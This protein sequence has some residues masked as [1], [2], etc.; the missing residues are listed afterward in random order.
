MPTTSMP[1]DTSSN[2]AY[3]AVVCRNIEEA[4]KRDIPTAKSQAQIIKRI[5]DRLRKVGFN[6]SN[7][8]V[9]EYA[10]HLNTEISYLMDALGMS[11]EER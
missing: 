7:K 4:G 9:I 5:A 6:T 1:K 3:Y 8:T 2:D 11:K 10:D